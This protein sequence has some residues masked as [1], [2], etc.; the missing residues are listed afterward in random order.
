MIQNR[1]VID[2]KDMPENSFVY[3]DG[4]FD[5]CIVNGESLTKYFGKEPGEYESCPIHQLLDPLS[6]LNF[7]PNFWMNT[8]LR[9]DTFDTKLYKNREELLKSIV[10]KLESDIFGYE[11]F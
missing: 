6:T 7:P 9:Y 11:P 5:Y 8:L 4:E 10:K 2:N 3:S 1:P